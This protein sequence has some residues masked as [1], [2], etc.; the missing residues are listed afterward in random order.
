MANLVLFGDS[1]CAESE[2]DGTR[3]GSDPQGKDTWWK[4]VAKTLG[5]GINN[6]SVRGTSLNYSTVKYYQY[7]NESYSTDD[8]IIFIVTS[9]GRSPLVHPDFL[10]ESAAIL[11]LFSSRGFSF[12]NVDLPASLKQHF[13]DHK[14]FYETWY[15]FYNPEVHLS[16]VNLIREALNGLSNK[17]L[18]INVFNEAQ[19]SDFTQQYNFHLDGYMMQISMEE[20]ATQDEYSRNRFFDTRPNHLSEENH[21]IFYDYVLKCLDGNY[22]SMLEVDFKKGFLNA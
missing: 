5:L 7:L 18:L 14:S 15:Q 4:D 19:S 3:G 10:P 16:Q 12:K 20:F 13:D 22:K 2:Y 9:S 1:F 8:I 21:K 6:Y 17:K 11:Q